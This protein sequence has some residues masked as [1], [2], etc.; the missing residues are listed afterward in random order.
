M[1][2]EGWA[3]GKNESGIGTGRWGW[4]PDGGGKRNGGW[5]MVIGQKQGY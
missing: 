4:G 2:D 3:L 5:E 1:V